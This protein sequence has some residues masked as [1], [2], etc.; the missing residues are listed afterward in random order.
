MRRRVRVTALA[1]AA[2]AGLS[3]LFFSPGASSRIL[4]YYRLSSKETVSPRRPLAHRGG[5]SASTKVDYATALNKSLKTDGESPRFSFKHQ[6]Q[7]APVQEAK[8]T[9]DV[10]T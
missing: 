3:L 10:I 9:P 5:S 6:E 2:F 4:N 8:I 7:Q 1:V